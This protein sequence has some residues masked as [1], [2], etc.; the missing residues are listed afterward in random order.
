MLMPISPLPTASGTIDI[1]PEL[2]PRPPC[3]GGGACLVH[4]T[5]PATT[6]RMTMAVRTKRRVDRGLAACAEPGED[7][8]WKFLI[9]WFMDLPSDEKWCA[10][11]PL[12]VAGTASRVR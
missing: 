12:F 2:R 1:G 8:S 3:S 4:Q 7:A 5:I 10:G 6:S 11:R 9:G